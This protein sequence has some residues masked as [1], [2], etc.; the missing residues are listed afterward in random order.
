MRIDTSKI[1]GVLAKLKKKDPVLF[2]R[3]QKKI[4]QI[5]SISPTE[6]EHFKNLMH[7]SS[8]YKRVQVGSFILFFRLEGDRIIFERFRHHDIAYRR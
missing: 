1:D 4:K 6:I 2:R 8:D 3:I 7:D 5:A